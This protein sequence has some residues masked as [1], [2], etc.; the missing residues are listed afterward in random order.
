MLLEL[1]PSPVFRVDG[2]PRVGPVGHRL[3]FLGEG[4]TD[5]VKQF[6]LPDGSYISTQL[7]TG[8]SISTARLTLLG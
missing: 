5:D 4:G 3:G 8:Q 6:V 2:P 1:F 7:Q